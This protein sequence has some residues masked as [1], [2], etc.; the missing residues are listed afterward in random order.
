MKKKGFTL[1]EL[2]AVIAILAI[3]IIIAIPNILELFNNAKKDTFVTEIRRIMDSAEKQFVMGNLNSGGSVYYSSTE[4]STLNTQP[5]NME[6]N[7]KEY[8]IEMDKEGDFKRVVV[9]DDNFCYDIYTNGTT[10]DISSTNSK[11][12]D[13]V[14]KKTIVVADDVNLSNNENNEIK[15][16]GSNYVVKGCNV[17]NIIDDI[18]SSDPTILYNV[19]K[20]DSEKSTIAKKYSGSHKDSFVSSSNK[21]IY[22]YTSS[23]TSEAE[24]LDNKNHVVF[25]G[26]CW[27][28]IRTTDTGGVKIMYNG[29][30]DS[31]GKCNNDR[32]AHLG[33][34]KTVSIDLNGNFYYSNDY[35]YDST[36]KK[37][38][39]TGDKI[40]SN[41]MDNT[42]RNLIGKYT[43]ASSDS[44]A[45]CDKLYFVLYRYHTG[46]AYVAEMS[47]DVSY[48]SI[49]RTRFN[50]TSYS[51][52]AVGYMFGYPYNYYKEGN[53]STGNRYFAKNAV[54]EN[55]K[56]R[57]KD[58]IKTGSS[59]TI[60]DAKIYHYTCMGESSLEC[61]ELG[62]LYS[63]RSG[64]TY[65]TPYILTNGILIEDAI[66]ENL[67][68]NKYSSSSK[69]ITEAWYEKYLKDTYSSYIEDTIFCGHREIDNYESSA[70][71]STGNNVDGDLNFTSND[72]LACPKETDQYSINNNNA[73]IKYPVGLI[74]AYEAK[75][76]GGNYFVRY[77]SSYGFW[78][79]TP[80]QFSG[81][82]YN[83]MV[84]YNRIMRQESWLTDDDIKPVISLKYGTK[85][86][87]GDGSKNNP[88][89]IK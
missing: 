43:C 11:L 89:I 24:T 22:Y 67:E 55:G 80:Y 69:L 53:M 44:N 15:F 7:G 85:Y 60:D 48:F 10:G 8:F 81:Y 61:E 25:A 70:W 78:S 74:T 23:D 36:S 28:M 83:N 29:E 49:G 32:A 57:L 66:K 63:Y 30:A 51:L 75:L 76:M 46:D 71:N 33:Y 40:Q 47:N 38:I 16:S 68:N 37:F 86:I 87:S 62:Y 21:D 72:S 79:M 54:Y 18:E 1:V 77:G 59:L 19:V 27:Q 3:L 50:G 82:A 84:W 26:F 88:Y 5:L 34:K 2:L 58:Y 64:Q 20:N 6:T 45:Q 17:N 9:Y 12:V 56:Y 41:W 73:K 39:L 4:N 65:I 35:S 52:A 13:D 42:Y 31:N 14:I